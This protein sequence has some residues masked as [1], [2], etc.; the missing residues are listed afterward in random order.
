MEKDKIYTFPDTEEAKQKV[1]QVV[2][3]LFEDPNRNY[4]TNALSLFVGLELAMDPDVEKAIKTFK[5]LN[6]L[7]KQ[8]IIKIKKPKKKRLTYKTVRNCAKRNR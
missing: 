3:G 5:K 6:Y 7:L 2:N 8:E 1:L 4:Y